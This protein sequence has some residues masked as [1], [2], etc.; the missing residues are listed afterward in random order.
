MHVRRRKLRQHGI[1]GVWIVLLV[2]LQHTSSTSFEVQSNGK[3][4]LVVPLG[5]RHGVHRVRGRSLL[6]SGVTA[7]HGAIREG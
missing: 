2:L 7:V 4:G 3:Y 5:I 6:R 1:F